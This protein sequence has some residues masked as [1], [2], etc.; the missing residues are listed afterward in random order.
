MA[1]DHANKFFVQIMQKTKEK[2]EKA[3]RKLYC[4]HFI[5]CIMY[6]IFHLNLQGLIIYFNRNCLVILLY[7]RPQKCLGIYITRK[8]SAI[9]ICRYFRLSGYNFI[10]SIETC[11]SYFSALVYLAYEIVGSTFA[12]V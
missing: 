7:S 2:A 11:M 10:L 12:S 5:S 1:T 9:S 8:F 6:H 3:R 4:C